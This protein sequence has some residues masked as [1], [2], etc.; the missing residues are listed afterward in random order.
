MNGLLQQ[1][2]PPAQQGRKA[3]PEEQAAYKN[4]V[5]Q[6]I[7]FISKPEITGKLE[8]M[9]KQHG[10]DRALAMVIMQA[11]QMVGKAAQSAG[12]NVA[13]HTGKAAIKEIVT[14]MAAMLQASGLTDNAQNTVQGVMQLL[15][16][17][18]FGAQ[19]QQQQPQQM[20]A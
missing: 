16:E 9:I 20:G 11:L 3:S 8:E 15:A 4:L 19:G 7:G 10:P 12:V 18:M 5:T 14:V 13:T 1:P 2:Q 17:S 6:V